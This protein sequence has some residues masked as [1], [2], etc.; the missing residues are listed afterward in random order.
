MYT[1]LAWQGQILLQQLSHQNTFVSVK[2]AYH[3]YC[4]TLDAAVCASVCT[5]FQTDNRFLRLAES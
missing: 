3:D 2:M 5:N 4:A 1:T